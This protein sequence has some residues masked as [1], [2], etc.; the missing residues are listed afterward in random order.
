MRQVSDGKGLTHVGDPRGGNCCGDSFTWRVL[1][2]EKKLCSDQI[3]A[4]LTPLDCGTM[5]STDCDVASFSSFILKSP[6]Y[7]QDISVEGNE[8]P[9]KDC[10]FIFAETWWLEIASGR[11]AVEMRQKDDQNKGEKNL[12]KQP[13]LSLQKDHMR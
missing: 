13:M 6:N 8:V 3:V 5:T 11:K 4:N 1:A 9:Q 10:H 2:P 12:T 7:K